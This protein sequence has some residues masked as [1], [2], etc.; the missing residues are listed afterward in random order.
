[1]RTITVTSKAYDD[2]GDVVRV[3]VNDGPTRV[4][5]VLGKGVLSNLAAVCWDVV[6][7]E[8]IWYVLTFTDY[9]CYAEPAFTGD[10]SRVAAVY[11]NEYYDSPIL[12]VL[13]LGESRR[14][15]TLVGRD[16]DTVPSALTLTPGAEFLIGAGFEFPGRKLVLH[17]WALAKS[18]AAR[19]P[20]WG[21][22]LK[23]GRMDSVTALAAS[24]DGRFVACGYDSGLVRLM[25]TRS[26]RTA[27]SFQAGSA[28]GVYSRPVVK[29]LAFSPDGTQLA[30][31]TYQRTGGKVGF[32]ASV[33]DVP[34]GTKVPSI[35]EEGSVNGFAFHPDG[36]TMLTARADGLV[37][38]WDTTTWKMSGSFDWKV[39]Q[40]FSVAYSPD[41]LL[42]TAG[43]EGGRIVVWDVEV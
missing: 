14:T 4:G 32:K 35:K 15:V 19:D 37:G 33:W 13:D 29:R 16:E 20:T 24:P 18:S 22:R 12:A 42:A 2:A 3:W 26:G 23:V 31:L 11:A 41:G 17:R 1:M 27:A 9:E 34:G 28:R 43:G 39:G 7:D 36:R 30:V 38:V 8:A 40:V 6:R 21:I 5:A 10:L 25:R